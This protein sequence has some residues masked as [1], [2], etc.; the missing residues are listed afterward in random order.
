MKRYTVEM[1]KLLALA[2]VTPLLVAAYTKVESSV[3]TTPVD[4]TQGAIH[5]A[6]P[7]SVGLMNNTK[8]TDADLNTT[9]N[10]DYI[11]VRSVLPSNDGTGN[12][13]GRK[14]LLT[15]DGFALIVL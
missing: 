3:S 11:V 15:T 14:P 5:S 10:N 6:T 1:M 4:Q 13:N 7:V 9:E 8:S 2:I 12:T